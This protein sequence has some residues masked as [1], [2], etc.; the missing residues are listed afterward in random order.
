MLSGSGNAACDRHYA[1]LMSL[2][3]RHG[4][5]ARLSSFRLALVVP[6]QLELNGNGS[7]PPHIEPF[8]TCRSRPRSG[9]ALGGPKLA[10][11][12]Y[13]DRVNLREC[14]ILESVQLFRMEPI[15]LDEIR[16][17]QQRIAEQEAK[18][19]DSGSPEAGEKHAQMA[20]LY[21]AQLTVLHSRRG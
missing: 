2:T 21:R 16:Y 5:Y 13:R 9:H 1:E 4:S 19:R 8:R 18:I 12:E 17:C 3:A 7:E 11:P 6:R 14:L 15:D 20:L 10:V